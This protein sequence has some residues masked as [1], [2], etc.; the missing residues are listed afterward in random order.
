MYPFFPWKSNTFHFFGTSHNA[1]YDE[2]KPKNT[3]RKKHSEDSYEH[4]LSAQQTSHPKKK[5][6]I[7]CEL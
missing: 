6:D 7:N 4:N 1:R 5:S 2:A 3:G